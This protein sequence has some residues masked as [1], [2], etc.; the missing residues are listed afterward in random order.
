MKLR[1]AVGSL[2]IAGLE[3]VE[4]GAL[5]SAWLRL[6]RPAGIILFRRNIEDA[7]QVHA[8]L[9]SSSRL[10][11]GPALRCVDLEGGLVDRLRDLVARVP[12]AAAVAATRCRKLS[13]EHGRL[14]GDEIAMVGFNTTL[15]P[16]LDL[17]L[18]ASAEV[19]RTRSSAANAKDVIA[20]A[21]PFLKGLKKAG[22]V[23]CGKHFPGLGGGTLDSHLATPEIDRGWQQ[24]WEDDLLPYRKLRKDLPVVMISHASYPRVKGARGTV[25]EPASISRHWI[26][27][28]LQRKI[29]Y[30]GLVLSDDME[31]GGVLTRMS[32]EEASI[33]AILAGTHLLE[34]CKEPALILR[35]FEA[36]L[37]ESERSSVFRRKVLHAAVHVE[38]Q[39][40]RLLS[41]P[42]AEQPADPDALEAMRKRITLFDSEVQ[43]MNALITKK[44]KSRG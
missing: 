5:E 31:M 19:M 7:G 17:A 24:L 26:H 44:T 4:L 21:G 43:R 41:R 32:I 35:T 11:A 16:V 9:Q 6:I 3:G 42:T 34:I 29:G 36:V 14:I 27:E 10:C 40:V 1:E 38:K 25:S 20:Y 39:K 30:R 13:Y 15:A 33:A 2:L 28:V 23:G 12:S 18:P 22:V 8:L 37:S